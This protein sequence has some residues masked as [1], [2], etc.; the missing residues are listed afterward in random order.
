MIKA[1]ELRIGN[2]VLAGKMTEPIQVFT[3]SYER[4][5]GYL[6]NKS[7]PIAHLRPI[8][9][10]PKIFERLGFEKGNSYSS[11]YELIEW[12][13]DYFYIYK[14]GDS[15]YWE[16]TKEEFVGGV[17]IKYIHQLQNLY[18][19]IECKELTLNQTSLSPLN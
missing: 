5:D 6:I 19:C 10:T 13:L 17:E 4:Q 15:F 16:R 12:R 8:P 11:S 3:I 18:Y 2:W 1:N 9:L 14:E 7:I